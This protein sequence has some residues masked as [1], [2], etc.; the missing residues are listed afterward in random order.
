MERYSYFEL[1]N[2]LMDG[3]SMGEKDENKTRRRSEVLTAMT[4]YSN[5]KER[6]NLAEQKGLDALVSKFF[7]IIE[8]K[9]ET[10][11]CYP[12]EKQ[13]RID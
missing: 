4:F 1:V 6:F 11:S 12:A 8:I 7:P 13:I 2:I 3:L 9:K 5:N 10:P